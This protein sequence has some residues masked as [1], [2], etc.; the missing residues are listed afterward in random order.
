MLQSLSDIA[1]GPQL[2]F[3]FDIDL[4]NIHE[5]RTLP[6]IL[7]SL[8]SDTDLSFHCYRRIA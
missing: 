8:R 1:Y 7:R 3:E 2:R 4:T 6:R 5:V